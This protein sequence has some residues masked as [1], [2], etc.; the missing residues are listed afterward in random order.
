M[1]KIYIAIC[2]LLTCV[3]LFPFFS[4]G[5]ERNNEK[6]RKSKY[7][8]FNDFFVAKWWEMNGKVWEWNESIAISYIS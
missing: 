5:K 2:F 7:K 4:V 8:A 1:N 3:F 6:E